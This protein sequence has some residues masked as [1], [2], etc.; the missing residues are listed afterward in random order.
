MR[1]LKAAAVW[2]VVVCAVAGVGFL[3]YRVLAA[4][5]EKRLE[6][7]MN[8]GRKAE[9]KLDLAGAV[10]MYEQVNS[11]EGRRALAAIREL[12]SFLKALEDHK[13]ETARGVLAKSYPDRP[14]AAKIV[15]NLNETRKTY[16]T[17]IE[18]ARRLE[19]ALE[20]EQAEAEYKRA[21]DMNVEGAAGTALARLAAVKEAMALVRTRKWSSAMNAIAAIR[22]H[23][24]RYLIDHC[25]RDGTRLALRG[26]SKGKPVIRIVAPAGGKPVEVSLPHTKMRD[27]DWTADARRLIY[28]ATSGEAENGLYEHDV[29]AGKT[30]LTAKLPLPG[31]A[32]SCFRNGQGFAFCGAYQEAR[33]VVLASA[34]FAQVT[35]IALEGSPR[36]VSAGRD[37]GFVACQLCV[38]DRSEIWLA[39]TSGRPGPRLSQEGVWAE[40]PAV[41]PDGKQVAFAM[42]QE[43]NFEIWLCGADGS[44][45]KRLTTSPEKDTNP[46]WSPDGSW[47]AYVTTR[48]K[49]RVVVV[50]DLAG[51][52]ETRIADVVGDTDPRPAW[53]PIMPDE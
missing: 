8:E 48:D 31:D 43:R 16:D 32:V 27:P 7:L 53:S 39:G 40:M 1:A 44:G 5:R 51:G 46:A 30:S 35:G 47:L 49:K 45:L 12:T 36:N 26:E 21:R 23:E 22:G 42:A 24:T 13:L 4:E 2:L 19:H 9:E 20:G 14:A 18:K 11:D 29:A 37:F 41:S 10:K 34:D 38:G 28:C 52:T 3:V 50:L 6:R 33:G 17:V 15:A 25:L